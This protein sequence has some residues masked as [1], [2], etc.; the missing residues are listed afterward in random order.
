MK[1]FNFFCTVFVVLIN[2]ILFSLAFP[3][4]KITVAVLD[5]AAKNISQESAD[6]VT[7]LLRTEL[8]NTGRFKVVERQ[9]IQK[10]IEE[11]KFQMSG[12]TD[13][14]QAAEIGRILNVQKIMVGTV[15]R[16]GTTHL[17]NVRLVDVQTGLVELAESVESRG[18]EG[19]LPGAIAELAFIIENKVG[20]EG[21]I[22]KVSEETVFIDLGSGDNVKLGQIFDVIRPGD[23]ITDLEGRIIGTRDEIIGKIEIIKIQDKFSIA[24]I[25]QKEEGIER[26]YK[27][28]PLGEEKIV[29]V[30]YPKMEVK[31]KKEERKEKKE[32]EEKKP[33]IPTIF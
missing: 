30:K 13:A 1:K 24:T 19:K 22:I 28:K 21:S 10:I 14:E 4:E 23:V 27:V 2:F 31:E 3:G 29:P 5:F 15:T 20:L 18:G 6:A 16:L 17:I 7:D 12:L 9:T 8:F 33:D 26:G 32:E 25:Q 11:Q